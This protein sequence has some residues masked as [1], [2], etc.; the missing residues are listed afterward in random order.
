MPTSKSIKSPAFQIYPKDFLSSSKVRKMSLTE[1]GA[2]TVLL[3]T[4]WLDGSLPDDPCELARTLGIKEVQFRKMWAGPLGQCFTE[5]HGRLTNDRLERER[6][7][8][9]DYRK[10]QKENADM[11]WDKLRNATALP[12][13]D[14]SHASGNALQSASASA[15][16]SAKKEKISAEPHSDSPPVLTF[17]T[18]GKHKTWPLKASDVSHWQE[19]FPTLDVLAECRGALAWTET[20]PPKTAKGM[21][22]FLVSWFNRAVSRGGGRVTAFRATGTDGRGRTGAPPPGKYDGIEEHD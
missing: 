16:A 20:N 21:P 14:P 2:Y 4:S 19:L 12:A 10:K 22:A 11:R 5:R 1:I 17:V 7:S 3:L 18:V 8:Q 13:S 6:K 9:A 15:S